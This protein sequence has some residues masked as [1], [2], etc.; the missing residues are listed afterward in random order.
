MT[1]PISAKKRDGRSARALAKRAKR[2]D[3]IC[4]VAAQCFATRGFHGTSVADVIHSAN[5]SRGTFYLYFDSKEA[6]FHELLDGFV[7]TLQES[8]TVVDPSNDTAATEIFDNIYR[9]LDLLFDNRHLAVML[10]NA[11]SG[12]NEMTDRKIR[13]LYDFLRDMV[14]GALVN[15]AEWGI[16]RP[17]STR[18]VAAAIIGSVKEVLYS[19]L[20]VEQV[21]IA[22]RRAVAQALFDYGLRGLLPTR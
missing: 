15:G 2:R 10:L 5:I 6:I 13:E 11:T 16:I 19:Y 7:N 1:P 18:I 21:D 9:V 8:I 3:Q 14:E 20:I 4:E 17:C 22:D 12:H